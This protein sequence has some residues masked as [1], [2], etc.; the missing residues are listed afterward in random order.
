MEFDP[1]KLLSELLDAPHCLTS[2]APQNERGL[3]GLIDHKGDLRYIGSTSSA[4]QTL[5]TRI[6]SRHRT[7]SEGMSHYFSEMYNTGRMW[8]DRKDAESESDGKIAKELRNEFIA[9][10]CRA[11]WVVLPDYA[12]IAA[13][14][15]KV[16]DIA[17]DKAKSW[18]WR[19]M[20][21]YDEPTELVDQT[22]NRLNWGASKLE[23]IDRQQK[24]FQ[25]ANTSGAN[26]IDDASAATE[27]NKLPPFPEG[28]F[29][30]F[31]LDVETANNDRGSICQIG[32][33]CVGDDNSIQTWKTFV[34]PQ[35][36]I[37]VHTS[38]HGIC[39]EMVG[40][41]PT[42][43]R[44]LPLL[45]RVLGRQMVYQHSTFDSTAIRAACSNLNLSE[46]AW[47]WRDS[48]KVAREA[49][50][51][52][53]GNG[54]HGLAKL[55][56]HLGLEF[57]HHDAGED[58][59]ASAAIVLMAESVNRKKTSFPDSV[60]HAKVEALLP[61][62]KSPQLRP[63]SQSPPLSDHEM[64]RIIGKTEI[65]E[66][67]IKNNHIYLRN[68]FDRFP[69]DAVGGSNRTLA[70]ERE[71]TL[72]WGG[73]STTSTDLDGA[74]KFFRNRSWVGKFFELNNIEAGDTVSVEEKG[75]YSY[76]IFCSCRRNSNTV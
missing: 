51:E 25:C 2:E 57:D 10:H 74:K 47:D 66:G 56:E 16:L 27:N 63:L 38:I 40:D 75:P 41:A 22:L 7:G 6:H 69:S 24:R 62:T 26:K 13:L 71:V 49:W 20:S 59:R 43:D 45:N 1:K 76:R 30:F 9:E 67:N 70:A 36:D 39:A 72:D 29:R 28:H 64:G 5:Y 35:V 48:V 73:N 33:A 50:P 12:D 4:K 37:W 52:L 53:R 54:G 17:P 3:Y 34:N 21:S 55:K 8:R 23:A 65:T 68:F 46:P 60:D 31:A 61:A 44:I 32:V 14:E 58:A 15:S 18:N 19:G 11:V 42:F